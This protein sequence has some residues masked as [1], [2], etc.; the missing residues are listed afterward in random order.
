MVQT[1]TVLSRQSLTLDVREIILQPQK[2]FTFLPGQYVTILVPTAD[3]KSQGR[4]YSIASLST[5][6]RIVVAIKLVPGGLASTYLER[7]SVTEQTSFIGPLGKFLLSALPLDFL[8]VAT[9]VGLAPF[10]P[11]IHALLIQ[12][13]SQ[14]I[15]LLLGFRQE[16]HLFY[17]DLFAQ[18]AKQYKNFQ[19]VCTLSQPSDAWPGPRGRVTQYLADHPQLLDNRQLYLCGNGSMIADVQT[20]ALAKGILKEHIFLEKYNNL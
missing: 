11:M 20:L 10:V 14:S 2:P 16:D 18:W 17:T 1:A 6:S 3:G 19:F 13:V 8:F 9:G 5:D 12:G 4:S 15:T 7:I